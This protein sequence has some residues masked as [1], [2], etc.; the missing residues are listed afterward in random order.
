M[1]KL[2]WVTTMRHFRFVHFMG[3]GTLVDGTYSLV[4]I[5]E[6]ERIVWNPVWG[7]GNFNHTPSVILGSAASYPAL[8]S[9]LGGREVLVCA[10]VYLVLAPVCAGQVLATWRSVAPQPGHLDRRKAGVWMTA[11]WMS[12][13]LPGFCASSCRVRCDSQEAWWLA[14]PSWTSNCGKHLVFT[15]Q[16]GGRGKLN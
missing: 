15:E 9:I 8:S 10:A 3:K 5:V 13:A 6:V 12:V 14:A 4:W 16:L 1:T 7:S 2:F 11:G